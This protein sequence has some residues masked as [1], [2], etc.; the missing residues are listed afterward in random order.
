M[1]RFIFILA[2]F[3]VLGFS[4][5]SVLARDFGTNNDNSE[6]RYDPKI[7]VVQREREREHEEFRNEIKERVKER[8]QDKKASISARLTELRRERVESY[9]NKLTTRLSAAIDRLDILTQRI[10]S[11]LATLEKNNPGTET[12]SI[13]T[14]ITEAKTKLAEA[15]TKLAALEIVVQEALDSDTPNDSFGVVR[16]GISEIKGLLVEVHRILVHIIGDIRGLRINQ[17]D[18]NG[19]T[20]SPT[21]TPAT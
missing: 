21:V 11:R 19:E 2:S 20:V 7:K 10:E 1:R 14:Q 6:N 5:A 4:S 8:I 17:E 9:W 13:H 3:V 12:T 18:L 15:K 16:E